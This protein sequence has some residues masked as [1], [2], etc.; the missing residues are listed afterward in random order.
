MIT[1][2]PDVQISYRFPAEHRID[3]ERW[4]EDRLLVD[5]LSIATRFPLLSRTRHVRL[6]GWVEDINP[7]FAHGFQQSAGN[8]S[9]VW[10]AGHDLSTDD[11]ASFLEMACGWRTYADRPDAMNLAI[12]RLA[13]SFSRPGGRFG[14]EDRILD[15]AIALEVLYGGTTGHKLA[16]RAQPFLEME[17]PLESSSGYTTKRGSSIT[18]GTGLCMGR[19]RRLPETFSTRSLRQAGI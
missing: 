4:F 3:L 1:A 16:R 11:V 9:D 17:K 6:P 15:V 13:G 7:N 8:A 10:P 2:C 5:L 14:L 19:R 12:R 18:C